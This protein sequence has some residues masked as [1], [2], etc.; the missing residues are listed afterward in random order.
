MT[1]EIECAVGIL[2]GGPAGSIM[3]R[4]L[5]ERGY[6]TLLVD[7]TGATKAQRAE[8]LPPAVQPI[9]DSVRLQDALDASVFCRE[10][11]ALLLWGANELQVKKF[12]NAA[13]LL[14]DR[15][16]FDHVLRIAAAQSGTRVLAP[17]SARS[18]Q[19]HP[20]GGWLVP[21]TTSSGP[22]LMRAR[23]LVDA[24]GRRPR[25]CVD[26]SAPSTVALSASFVVDDRA[27]AETR[28][29]AGMDA[30]F[31]GSP[32]PSR[33]YAAA[34]F[35]DS[36]RAAGLGGYDRMRLYRRLLSRSKLLK[37]LL[38][39]R[40]CGP[41]SVRDAT[42]RLANDLIGDD[43]I[44]VGE[45]A[46]AIDPLS[47]QGI[48]AALLSAIQGSAAVHT[49]LTAS[50]ESGAAFEFYRERQQD[51]AAK[52]RLTAA[53][54]YRAHR[55]E[56]QFWKKRQ[57]AA[58]G[59][60]ANRPQRA[61]PETALPSEL[62]VSQALQIVE[63]P[64]LADGLVRRA[65]ALGHP[66][67]ERPT[68]YFAEVALAPLIDDIGDAH[69]T[70]DILSRWMRHVP[71]ETATKIMNWMWSIRILDSHPGGSQDRVP[72]ASR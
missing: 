56:S 48:Q 29:E 42:S 36:A 21:I 26:D 65:R 6:D 53:R 7:R 30:W 39:N 60:F 67:L 55:G 37:N 20:R 10:Q 17:A 25:A 51:L 19:R 5:A 40:F 44:R 27:F 34:A 63:V 59:Q 72:S 16:H 8:S 57:A 9:L 15:A 43:F 54:F 38:T 18:P 66:R 46:V 2:G 61:P 33:C 24:R 70:E 49:I 50:F 71:L 11:R 14:V 12:D 52:S 47:S 3:A 45:A 32:L 28:I 69:A 23:F 68:A 1:A 64:V 13:S 31:W 4:Q 35:L 22:V 41:V 58:D 62:R